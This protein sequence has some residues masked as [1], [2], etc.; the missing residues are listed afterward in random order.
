MRRLLLE[1]GRQ[2][3]RSLKR[4]SGALLVATVLGCA[5]LW[6]VGNMLTRSTNTKVT[7]PAFP[8]R[9]VR[10]ASTDGVELA[11]SYW[12]G[13]EADAPAILMLHG[14]GSN[15]G[16][17]SEGASWLNERG[18]AV[19]AVDLRG[20]GESS[21]AEKSFGLHE[22]DDAQAALSWLRQRNPGGRIG[23]V[24]FSLGGAASLIGPHGP[25]TVDA[26]VLEGVYPD[27]RRAIFNRLAIRLG[28]WP[29][30][31]AEPL[32]SYQSLPRFSEDSWP[33]ANPPGDRTQ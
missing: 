25:L 3:P 11:G 18:Y 23:I 1:A 32:L 8:A 21:P 28:E 27:I 15:R 9:P 30:T 10:I 13:S 2:L 5:G 17:M 4:L 24:G 26:L 22:A 14:N 29:A 7:A 6:G 16:S 33:T 19:L 31:F 20:H 12:P